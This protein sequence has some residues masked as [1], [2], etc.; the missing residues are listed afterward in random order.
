MLAVTDAANLTGNF[1][2]KPGIERVY[3]HPQIFSSSALC[4]H[5]KEACSPIA[6]PPDSA[7]LEG[8]PTIPPRY[9]RVRAEVLEC[10]EGQTD[11][12]T[13]RHTDGRDRYTFRLGYVLCEL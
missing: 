4:C 3:K 9:I 6:N 8:T 12:H 11:R 1:F 7:Q 13:E 5:S 2:W 10:G